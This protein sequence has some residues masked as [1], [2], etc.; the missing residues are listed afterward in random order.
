MTAAFL[1]YCTCLYWAIPI[2]AKSKFSQ[3][4]PNRA[5]PE[6]NLTK[7]KAWFSL[8]F[9]VRFEPFQGLALTPWPENLFSASL[10]RSE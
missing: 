7:K 3:I 1:S 5:A 8:D 4:Q 10:S 2:Q 6:Q 9:L